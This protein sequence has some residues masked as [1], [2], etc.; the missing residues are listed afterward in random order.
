MAYSAI[1]SAIGAVQSFINNVVLKNCSLGIKNYT[2]AF[3]DHVDYRTL[4]LNFINVLPKAFI[5]I[6]GD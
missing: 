3:N 1:T 2:I 4:L 5:K 6:L